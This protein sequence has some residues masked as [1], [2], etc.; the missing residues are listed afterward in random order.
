[1]RVG[2]S[3]T[4]RILDHAC[5]RYPV[6]ISARILWY[7][8]GRFRSTPLPDGDI[9]LDS[10][11][12]TAWKLD[13]VNGY[14]WTMEQYAALVQSR[15]WAWCAAMDRPGNHGWSVAAYVALSRLCDV[16]PC[17]QGSWPHEYAASMRDYPGEPFV[18]VGNLVGRRPFE[19]RSIVDAIRR[20]RPGIRLHLFGVKSAA[21]HAV[22]HWAE[23]ASTDSQAWDF[24]ARKQ[25]HA[26][27]L[28]KT[29]DRRIEHMDRWV[30]R[31]T[32]GVST[33]FKAG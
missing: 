18:C 12:Y 24:R 25:C 31:Q 13:P 3:I 26:D 33:F 15:E 20:E 17:L 8:S 28:T 5:E 29:L 11:G 19:V 30:R 1:M 7:A 9:A 4:G 14:P 16:V 32:D 2:V 27:G 6:L 23:V 21:W 22:R 10:G